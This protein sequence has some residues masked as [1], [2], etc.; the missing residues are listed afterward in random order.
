MLKEEKIRY[1][2]IHK[3]LLDKHKIKLSIPHDFSSMVLKKKI[4]SISANT[5]YS[6]VYF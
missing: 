5:T 2:K 6:I 4:L 3:K 1:D